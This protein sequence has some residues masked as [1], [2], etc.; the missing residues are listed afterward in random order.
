MKIK[1]LSEIKPQQKLSSQEIVDLILSKRKIKDKKNFLNPPSPLNLKLVDFGK[2]HHKSFQ[3]AIELLKKIKEKQQM[4]IVYTDYD[5]DGI[6]GGAI[7]WETLYLLGFKTMPYVPHRK[8][9]GYGFS[10][11]GIDN[12]ISKYHPALII[13]VDHGIS[14]AEKISYA[15]KKGIPIIV[16]DHHLAPKKLPKDAFVIFHIPALSG[17]GVAYIFAKEIFERFKSLTSNSSL[18]TTNYLSLFTNFS[19]DY[20][21]LA[22]TGIV[23]DLVPLIG[24]ARSIVKF[25]LDAFSN[26]SRVGIKQILKQ[27]GLE[28]KPIT[29]Y[30]IGFMIAP[31]INAVGRLEHAIDALRL[32]CT[33]SPEKAFRLAEH[34]GDLNKNRQNLVE[35]SVKAAREMLLNEKQAQQ[36]NFYSATCDEALIKK[37]DYITL[38]GNKNLAA[39]VNISNNKTKRADLQTP[40]CD[41]NIV[42]E[43]DSIALGGFA[44]THASGVVIPK[45][46]ILIS[47]HWN[48]GIIGLIASKIADEFYRPTIIITKSNNHY[49][50][51]ARSIS[52]FDI[53]KFL[54]S[55]KKYLIDVGGHAQAAGFTIEEKQLKDFVK[56]AQKKANKLLTEKDLEP[57][58]KADLK[59]PINFINLS[60]YKLLTLLEPF[61]IGNPRPTFYSE[62]E[63]VDAQIFGKTHT[64][65]KLLVKNPDSKSTPLE[66]IYFN[67]A[68]LFPQLARGQIIKIVYSIN[69]NRWNG[70]ESL[71]GIVRIV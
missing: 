17:A 2:S 19:Y 57:I 59:I 64:H 9:E 24:P 66:M 40:T 35:K 1:F 49:K 58:T 28:E 63:L 14:A 30:E 21:A 20:L 18:L 55:L 6:T 61:G 16:T 27:A 15:K 32:L 25:G 47:N 52:R 37:Q 41:D 53:T 43:K 31:R 45:L 46:V 26:V 7:L 3:K 70:K 69:L 48:E 23:A 39:S 8:N 71:R 10:I 56:F 68:N 4:I 51:S 44:K 29:P 50:G 65:L 13:S 34:L 42:Q 67:K 12:V 38:A 60:L 33:N 5:A 36:A 54:R 11:Q 22:A 62:A